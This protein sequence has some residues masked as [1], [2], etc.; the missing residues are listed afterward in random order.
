M[1]LSEFMLFLIPA[2]A[3]IGLAEQG[4]EASLVA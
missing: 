2:L 1:R 4:F 3:L